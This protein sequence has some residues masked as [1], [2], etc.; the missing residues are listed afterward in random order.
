MNMLYLCVIN[1]TDKVRF[2]NRYNLLAFMRPIF[3]F[4]FFT[5]LSGVSMLPGA[6]QRM[7]TDLLLFALALMVSGACFVFISIT[8]IRWRV[9]YHLFA[10]PM[11]IYVLL[12]IAIILSRPRLGVTPIWPLI[13][14]LVLGLL[15]GHGEI[16]A[17][18]R[19][20]VSLHD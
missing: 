1:G 3:I 7:Q 17:R 16:N 8:Q 11:T 9:I 10:L 18:V 20:R 19:I 4:G 12:V 5:I 2:H 6:V 15:G 13:G 14:F